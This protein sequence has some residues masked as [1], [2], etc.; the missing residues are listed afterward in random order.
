MQ[1][2]DCLGKPLSIWLKVLDNV[3]QIKQLQKI[4]LLPL[5]LNNKFKM[6]LLN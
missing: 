5:L 3:I 1:K 4:Y 6:Q 2:E